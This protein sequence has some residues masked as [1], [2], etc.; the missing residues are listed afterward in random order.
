MIDSWTEPFEQEF[1][2]D[3][4]FAIYEVPMINAAW[5]VFSWMIDSG[6]RKG[7]PVEKHNNVV[8][9]YGDYSTYQEVLGM[10]DTNFA[11]VYLLDQMGFIR[12]KGKG[13]SSLE[14]LKELIGIAE[15]L[16]TN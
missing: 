11:Y 16:K 3:S 15:S 9:Y 7:I 2:K 14:T 12:W 8:T 5:K 6:M 10:E 13:F 1:G 4:R